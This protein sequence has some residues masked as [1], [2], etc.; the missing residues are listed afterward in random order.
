V[1]VPFFA[2]RSLGEVVGEQN[3]IRVFLHSRHS[4]ETAQP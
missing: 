4:G 2:F 1:L 3:L